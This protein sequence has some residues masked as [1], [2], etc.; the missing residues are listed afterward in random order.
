MFI[1]FDTMYECDRH[2]T[3]RHTDKHRMTAENT[4]QQ[5]LSCKDFLQ[6][7]V[8]PVTNAGKLRKLP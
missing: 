2:N 8:R 4:V 1:R 6:D 3:D 7:F 5:C